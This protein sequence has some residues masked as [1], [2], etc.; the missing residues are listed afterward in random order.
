MPSLD[1]KYRLSKNSTE[2][3]GHGIA[4]AKKVMKLS[5]ARKTRAIAPVA[6][7]GWHILGTCKM[8]ND[9]EKSVVDKFGNCIA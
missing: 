6:E 2:Q 7:T 5:G 3:L 1:I 9:P 8:G 4:M